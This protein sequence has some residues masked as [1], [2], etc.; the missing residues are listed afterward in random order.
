MSVHKG[1]TRLLSACDNLEHTNGT[2]QETSLLEEDSSVAII[3]V[4]GVE[5][6]NSPKKRRYMTNLAIFF[7]FPMKCPFLFCK[8]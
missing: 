4:D 5:P 3:P 1:Q 6:H 2:A 7:L 8:C